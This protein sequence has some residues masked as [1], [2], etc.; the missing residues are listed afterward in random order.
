MQKAFKEFSTAAILTI[1]D[2]SLLE[3][4]RKTKELGFFTFIWTQDAEVNLVIDGVPATVPAHSIVSLTPIQQLQYLEDATVIVYQF[5]REFYCIK[6]HDQEVGCVGLLFYGNQHIPIVTLDIKEQKKFSILHQVID[7][8]IDTADRIQSE[9]LQ[10]LVARFIIKTTRLL[11]QMNPSEKSYEGTSELLRQYNVLVEAHFRES[12][13]VTF[14]AEKLHKSPKTL[15]NTFGKVGKSPLRII[16]DRIILETKRLLR[17]S[18]K[19]TKEI[20][21]EVG[22]E[23][24]SHLS[25]LFKKQ[26]GTSPSVFKKQVGIT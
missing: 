20:A 13:S 23:D 24:A 17:Y 22:F 11:K 5:N 1:G 26:T 15:S 7:D 19:T 9:M 12:H 16:H 18:N 25:R 4:F 21:Y 2:Q 3:P 10:M 8:E 6:D 14:Y